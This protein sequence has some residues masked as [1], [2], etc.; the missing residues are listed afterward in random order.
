MAVIRRFNFYNIY[1]QA[2]MKAT[3][4]IAILITDLG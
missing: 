1:Y 4:K 2:I 3:T